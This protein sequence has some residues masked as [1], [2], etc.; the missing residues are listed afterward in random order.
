MK[1][2]SGIPAAIIIGSL[3]ISLSILVSSGSL[4][5]KK[6]TAGTAATI[7]TVP[8]QSTQPSANPNVNVGYGKLPVKG[9]TDAKVAII[10]FADFRCPFCERF[11]QEVEQQLLKDYVDTGKAKFAFRHFEFLGPASITAGNAAECANEQGKFWE[12]HDYLFKNQPSE[13][14]IS[15]FNSDKLT[16][17]ASGLALDATKFKLCLD[18]TKYNQNLT[19]DQKDG[20]AAGV[21]GTPSI[22]IGKAGPSGVINGKL[23]VGAQPLNVFQ[24]AIDPLLK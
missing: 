10:E 8:L 23:I 22:I 18:S 11:Y 24:S 14:D 13:S 5:L 12:Y 3:L 1:D 7:A 9:S 21:S 4:K 20:Q 19:Q 15:M 17:I 16:S 6:N 2:S